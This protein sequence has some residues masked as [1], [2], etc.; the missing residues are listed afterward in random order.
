MGRNSLRQLIRSRKRIIELKDEEKKRMTEVARV[1]GLSRKT[2]YKWYNRYH[3]VLAEGGSPEEAENSL[4]DKSSRP[5]RFPKETPT[6][7]QEAVL[8]I[9]E[10]KRYGPLRIADE[11]AGKISPSG[12]YQV[13][14]RRGENRLRSYSKPE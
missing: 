11:L 14:K 10:E 13:L 2:C 1:L 3:K 6:G 7:L 12:V 9:R 4:V 8:E 5:H